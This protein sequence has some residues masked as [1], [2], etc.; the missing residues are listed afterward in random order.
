MRYR[1]PLCGNGKKGM[2]LLQLN[3]SEPWCPKEN[4]LQSKEIYRLN[5]D[6]K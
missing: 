1:E 5:A 3:A 2:V 6:E 4:A